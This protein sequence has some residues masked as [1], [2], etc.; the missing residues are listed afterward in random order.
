MSLKAGIQ[1]ARSYLTIL[2]GFLI[3]FAIVLWV[4]HKMPKRVE[5]TDSIV[6][7]AHFPP[8]PDSRDLTFDEAVWARIAWQYFVD[9]TQPGGLVNAENGRPWLSLWHT[10]SYLLAVISA[11]Q[12]HVIEDAEFDRRIAA[13]LT[14]LTA[15]PVQADGLPAAFYH[16][17]SL[18]P[19][20][21][22]T[23]ENVSAV[24]MGRLL[25]P[26]QILLWRYPQ[27]AA[28]VNTLLAK[29]PLAALLRSSGQQSAS[30]PVNRWVLRTNDPRSSYGYRLYAANTLR[31]INSAASLAVTQPPDGLKMIEIDGYTVPDEGLRTPWGQQ[32]ALVSL[33]YLLTGLEQ[34]WDARSGEI[35]WRIMQILQQRTGTPDARDDIQ[36]DY[37]EQAPDFVAAQPGNQPLPEPMQMGSG[38]AALPTQALISTRSAFAWYALFRTGWS[39]ALRQKMLPMIAPGKGWRAGFNQDGS[40]SDVINADTNAMVLESLSYLVHGP[41][42]C[43]G[44]LAPAPAP[45]R[46]KE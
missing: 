35:A 10:G 29:W 20:A 44:C 18:L 25:M 39:D 27:H 7:N 12:L 1:S 38:S 21:Q 42:L 45:E 36:T 24:D 32:P 9:N 46:N 37:A 28:A 17:D 13:A 40:V 4:E 30:L 31:L 15:L 2:I 23:S 11:R 3:G 43:L 8:L 34:G 41:L 14:A 22:A 26:L 5:T 19:I 6:L 33:P 16:A